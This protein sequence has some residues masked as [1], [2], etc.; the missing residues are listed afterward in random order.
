MEKMREEILTGSISR[1]L[2]KLG[3]PIMV[4]SLMQTAYNLVDIF[5]LGHL[6]EEGRF[7]LAALQISWPIVFL[8]ISLGVGFGIAGI[9]LVSQYT[10]AKN[11]RMANYSAGQTLSLAM[12]FSILIAVV[13]F[14]FSGVL[15]SSIKAEAQV[16]KLSVQYIRIIFLGAP[17]MFSFVSF[18]ML[19]RGY[20][21]TVTPMKIGIVSVA[22]NVAVDPFLI[23]GWG[24]PAMGVTG[25]AIS[26]VISRGIASIPSLYLLFSGRVGVHILAKDLKPNK[27][28]V[29]KILKIGFPASIGFTT[30]AFGFFILMYVVA[31]V[32]NS[33]IALAAYGIGDRIINMMFIVI[34]GLAFSLT[35]LIGQSIGGE[36][37]KRAEEAARKGIGLMFS[38]LLI[39]AF[40]LYGV[41]KGA[42]SIFTSDNQIIE[43]GMNFLQIFSIGIPFFGIFRGVTALYDGSGHTV[44]SM[45]M[46]LT[47]LW[48]LRV[49]LCYLL[50][51]SIGLQSSG[52]WWGMGISNIVAAALAIFFYSTGAWK[53]EVI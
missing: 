9:A 40:T 13:G 49:P 16:T 15:V 37:I 14:F 29:R 7:A 32:S 21:D 30:E 33:T 26:T 43:G 27:K 45:I 38:L 4:T 28:F 48:V 44:P 31:R 5:W 1:V 6:P 11:E 35:T 23:F 25:A 36:R 52:I 47:R 8:L 2:F 51:I 42:I 3:W 19:L 17:F 39:G 10:G 46:G 22:L 41:R 20:G 50:G 18:T 12:I 34:D 24:F 53:K